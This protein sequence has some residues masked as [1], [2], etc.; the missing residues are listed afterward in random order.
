MKLR[1]TMVVG[2]LAAMA[3]V[4]CTS[5]GRTEQ[6]EDRQDLA[7]TEQ[8][9]HENVAE[10]RQD[11]QQNVNDAQKNLAQTEQDAQQKVANAQQDA[12]QNINE[13]RKDLAKDQTGM[14][15]QSGTVVGTLTNVEKDSLTVKDSAGNEVELK[16]AE[17]LKTAG[18]KEG[19]EVRANYKVD[20]KG[21]KWAE[22][23]ELQAAPYNP[24][25]DN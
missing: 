21:D 5:N 20:D 8:N 7:Q 11:A 4:G 14:A 22:S 9:A 15:S 10:A 23:V 24:T 6:A 13:E 16:K 12:Q 25:P 18:L 19:S 1:M 2:A 17:T 3:M